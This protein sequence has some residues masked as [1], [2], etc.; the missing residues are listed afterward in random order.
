MCER[1]IHREIDERGWG[2]EREEEGEIER[3]GKRER[4]R[5]RERETSST[6]TAEASDGAEIAEKLPNCDRALPGALCARTQVL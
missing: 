1:E 4:E 2:G 3:E 6:S 5:E